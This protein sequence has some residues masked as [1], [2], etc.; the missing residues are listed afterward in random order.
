MNMD[1]E[2]KAIVAAAC[3]RW[4]EFDR[5]CESGESPVTAEAVLHD[6]DL[7][8]LAEAYCGEHPADENE[9]V[10]EEW[11]RSVGFK[12]GP[13]NCEIAPGYEFV[14]QP[15]HCC[16]DLALWHGYGDVFIRGGR[17]VFFSIA[18]NVNT[19]GRVR[20]LCAAL[21]ISLKEGA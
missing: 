21:G 20:R 17:H 2:E 12:H 6:S 18:R 14:I 4:H 10:T 3:Q 19:R 8:I 13:E 11:L 16:N 15:P 5:R 9:P 1:D 7:A